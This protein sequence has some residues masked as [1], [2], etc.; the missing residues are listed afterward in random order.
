[1]STLEGRLALRPGDWLTVSV[2]LYAGLDGQVA[3]VHPLGPLLERVRIRLHLFGTGQ[4]IS[5][6]HWQVH[7]TGPFT[8]ADWLTD[9]DTTRLERFLL[10]LPRPPSPRKW[11]LYAC[12]CVRRIVPFA[13]P[14]VQDA[15]AIA[16]R[17]AEGRARWGHLNWMA[18]H[19]IELVGQKPREEAALRAAWS[20]VAPGNEAPLARRQALRALGCLS[21]AQHQRAL[22]CDVMGNPFRPVRL[23]PAWLDWQNGLVL[24]LARTIYR[25]GSFTDLPIL[26]D[27]LEDAGCTDP[28]LLDHCRAAALH[29]RGCWLLDA[30]AAGEP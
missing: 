13:P 27:A 14:V 9:N 2:G 21:E 23:E 29:T 15:L 26:G 1:M 11:R 10:G 18:R 24:H 28:A 22:L 6:D 5:L 20:T 3:E 19:L 17:F 8:E 4:P 25:D 30:L 16:E 7:Y 12:A